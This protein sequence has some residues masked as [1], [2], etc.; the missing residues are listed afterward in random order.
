VKKRVIF[1][2]FILI[3]TLLLLSG[4][5][6]S[7]RDVAYKDGTYIG[8]SSE[9][10]RGA[11]GE[12]TITI[13]GNQIT[14]CKYVTWQK[15]G[16][17]KGENYGKVNGAISNQDYYDKAQLAVKAMKQYAEKLVEV[18][19]LEDVDA[20]SGATIAYNQFNEAVSSALDEAKE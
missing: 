1:I 17:V 14:D 10:D 7:S 16:A 8:K 4:C 11:Y 15:D 20:I 19:N 12:A 3:F 13:K 6:N 5:K 2:S 9:D 18:Q